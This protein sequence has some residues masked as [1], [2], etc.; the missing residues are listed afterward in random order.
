MLLCLL[1][2]YLIMADI[3]SFIGTSILKKAAAT[4]SAVHTSLTGK[5]LFYDLFALI[6]SGIAKV[7]VLIY[8]NGEDSSKEGKTLESAV[9]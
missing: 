9:A 7:A 8:T 2:A 4:V 1:I 6:I 5:S 3:V